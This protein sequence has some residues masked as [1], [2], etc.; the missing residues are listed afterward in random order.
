MDQFIDRQSALSLRRF[1]SQSSRSR[2]ARTLLAVL[3]AISLV[4]GALLALLTPIGGVAVLAAGL[5][6]VLALRDVRWGLLA[7]I[8][9]ACL[10]P[11]ASL[12]FKVG[13]TPTFLDLTFGAVYAVWAVRLFTRTQND[14]IL[15]P[16][17][18]PVLAF[19]LLAIFSFLLGLAHAFPTPNDL[20]TFA[21]V[22]MGICIFYLVVNN[23]RLESVLR[24]LTRALIAA[25]AAQS[26]IGIA[27]YV[28]PEAWTVRALNPLARLGYPVGYGALRYINDDP[29]RPMRAIGT[30]VDP[31]I[32]GAMLVIILTLAG[33]QLLSRNPVM[34]RFWLMSSVGLMAVC[35]FLTY[36]RGSLV[37]AVAALG[38]VSLVRYRRL[39]LVL[40]AMSL[41]LLLLP[42]TQDYV[43]HF[44]QG[45]E[46][47]DRST[48]MRM[49]E[50]R[51]ALK[52]I[53]RYPWVG[54]GFV[55]APDVDLYLGVASIYFAL[56]S[57]MGI[58]GLT[59][60]LVVMCAF[61]VIVALAW[62]DQP[63]DG[64]L[65]PMLL[66]YGAA[67]FGS[68]FSGLLDHTL[69]TYPHA[70]A[71]LWLTLGL[72]VV[73]ARMTQLSRNLHAT[74]TVQRAL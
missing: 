44:A 17:G 53:Q 61:F 64:P 5:A 19:V 22:L 14:F 1:I 3:I 66:G 11:F 46:I 26:L 2:F 38:A 25:G 55:G 36:S 12:P 35:L 4:C 71:L 69:L 13:F 59:S 70:G 39:L 54:V 23:V 30:C 45:I 63:R 42:Q 16:L 48:Q 37:G 50:Y 32:L 40:V 68:L 62:K 8:A 52:L 47:E 21:E 67:V 65:E 15:T 18:L 6:A 9:V 74:E 56:A 31:N 49:G 58:V 20:R 24:L 73:S 41:L 34:P 57:Q 7:V 60:F 72:G 29:E 28:L 27:F 43:A 10:L 33:V 51:D